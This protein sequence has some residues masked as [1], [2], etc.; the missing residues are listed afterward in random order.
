MIIR[1]I[2]LF[3][4]LIMI[5]GNTGIVFAEET[6][7]ITDMREKN[8]TI[9]SN[10][11]NVVIMN[12]GFLA[13]LTR[14]MKVSDRIKA[15][16]GLIYEWDTDVKNNEYIYLNPGFQDLPNVHG[17]HD[18]L[19]TETLASANP[20]LVI[21]ENTEYTQDDQ[22]KAQNDADIETIEK[23]LQ[24]PL[25]VVKGTALYGNKDN[26]ATYDTV[27]LMGEIF[28]RQ[29]KA[30]K[31]NAAMKKRIDEIEERT[32]DIPAE[33]RAKVLF[34]GLTS[35]LPSPVWPDAYG[36]AKF[37]DNILKVKNLVTDR[38]TKKISAEQI[39]QLNPEVI[40]LTTY[41]DK[42]CNP[43]IFKEDET[44]KELRVVDAVKNERV[45]S[46]GDMTWMGD[47]GLDTPII[48]MT[49]AKGAYPEKFAD[50]NVRDWSLDYLQE[51][52]DMSRDEAATLFDDIMRMGW[53]KDK[54]F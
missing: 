25:V 29:E 40:I 48:L 5:T 45:V 26:Q 17:S 52:Y 39:I 53:T 21:W 12:T 30:E 23:T 27:T 32:K 4:V 7:T 42:S 33:K 11:Q 49:E 15:T 22:N 28:N 51:I 14:A 37:S 43:D 16:G 41:S 3:L 8:I 9:P 35:E 44:F 31:I 10:P 6:K 47:Y 18:P 1:A 24:I 20:D 34:L 13:Q 46:A 36:D 38:G 19:S 2:P 50:I 54:G